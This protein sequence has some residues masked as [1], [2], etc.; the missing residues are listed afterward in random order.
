MVQPAAGARVSGG[1][2]RRFDVKIRDGQISHR[3][4]AVRWE[5][6]CVTV[7]GEPRHPRLWAGDSGEGLSESAKVC[8]VA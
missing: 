1:L 4:I 2:H 3:P 6:W 7:G 8:A 5:I